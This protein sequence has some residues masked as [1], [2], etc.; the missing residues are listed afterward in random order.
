MQC[1]THTEAAIDKSMTDTLFVPIKLS[2]L[3]SLRENNNTIIILHFLP[4]QRSYSKLP[5]HP[6]QTYALFTLPYPLEMCLH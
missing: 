1:S 6:S 4:L 2:G 5:F 3:S